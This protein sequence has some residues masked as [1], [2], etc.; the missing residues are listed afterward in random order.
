[1]S[2][3]EHAW[4]ALMIGVDDLPKA[5]DAEWAVLG[6]VAANLYRA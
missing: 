3:S 1:M 2:A 5:H 6:A 4:G